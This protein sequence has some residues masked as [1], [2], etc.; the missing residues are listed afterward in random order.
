[1]RQTNRRLLPSGRRG[2]HNRRLHRSAALALSFLAA[3]ATP[4]AAHEVPGSV[5]VQVIVREQEDRLAILVRAP[6]EAMQEMGIPADVR[7]ILDLEAAQAGGALVR[8]AEVWIADNLAL[9]LGGRELE[10]PTVESVRVS[11]PSDRSFSSYDGAMNHMRG[12]PLPPTTRIPWKQAML[13]ALLTT[14]LETAQAA[15]DRRRFAVDPRF[16]RLGLEVLVTLRYESA[17]GEARAFRLAAEPGRVRLDPRRGQAAFQFLWLGV[18]HILGG[19]DH[20]LFLACLVVPLRRFKRLLL[21]VTSFTL[22]HSMTLIVAAAGFAPR[23]LWFPA[24]VETLIA[25]SIVHVAFEN[26]LGIG[27]DRRWLAAFGFGL[28]HGFGFSFALSESLQFAGAHFVTSLLAFNLG[29]EIGQILVLILLVPSL[30]LLFRRTAGERLPTILISALIAHTAWHW[31]TA[32]G[33]DLL[34]Y[35]PAAPLLDRLPDDALLGGFVAVAL[36]TTAWRSFRRR[37]AGL[38]RQDPSAAG[39]QSA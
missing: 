12:P 30:D 27:R 2:L 6:L 14:P 26:I 29:V 16:G 5:T 31:M 39:S 33:S 13:D 22:A 1:M 23:A 7:G 20:L 21:V 28:V 8:A 34:A 35:R 9:F 11:L 36:A 25:L 10:R 37:G 24:L 19:L 3:G 17:D 15:D 18:E 38:R 4:A 32:R